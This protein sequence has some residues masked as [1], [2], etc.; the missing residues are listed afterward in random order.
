LIAIEKQMRLF[1]IRFDRGASE[2][3]LRAKPAT[4]YSKQATKGAIDKTQGLA[5]KKTKQIV[6]SEALQQNSLNEFKID[7]KDSITAKGVSTMI[8]HKSFFTS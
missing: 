7:T 2:L 4:H 1:P 6:Y 5:T 8:R 3:R